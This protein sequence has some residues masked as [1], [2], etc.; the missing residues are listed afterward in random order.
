MMDTEEKA[1]ESISE[2]ER[3]T[4]ELVKM[5]RK[6]A[7]SNAELALAKSEL[8]ELGYRYQVLQLYRK[9]NLSEKDGI[10]E[11]GQI[12]KNYVSEP[13]NNNGTK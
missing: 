12:L 6:L 4:L 3:L 1:V 11:Q 10:D 8:A 7:S 13:G 2:V 9:Y 5:N